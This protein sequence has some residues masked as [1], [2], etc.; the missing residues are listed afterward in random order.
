MTQEESL[1]EIIKQ[2][3]NCEGICCNDCPLSNSEQFP[4][5]AVYDTNAFE[6]WASKNKTSAKEM[7]KDMESKVKVKFKD[8]DQVLSLRHGWGVVDDED[9]SEDS[10]VFRFPEIG[11]L[12]YEKDGK[13][14]EEDNY[15]TAF[16]REEAAIKFPEYP[17]PKKRVKKTLTVWNTLYRHGSTSTFKDKPDNMDKILSCKEVVHEWEQEE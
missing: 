14:M 16:T 12:T 5:C 6:S 15:P 1:K 8:G 10:C 7:L 3:G 11:N 9:Y 4:K 13:W 2:D 17:A